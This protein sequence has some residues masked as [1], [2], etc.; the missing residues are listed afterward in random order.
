MTA[1]GGTGM[2]LLLSHDEAHKA[3]LR[4]AIDAGGAV[5]WN[6]FARLTGTSESAVKR[7]WA[8]G[9]LPSVPIDSIPIREGIV[10]LCAIPGALRRGT[11]TPLWLLEFD[12]QARA[13]LGLPARDVAEVYEAR[14]SSSSDPD[15]LDRL[16]MNHLRAQTANAMHAAK[17]K[18]F[19][20][21]V[22]RGEYVK[23]S[24]VELDAAECAT[25]VIGVLQSL[26]A[27]IGAACA[28]QSALEIERRAADEI[29]RAVRY[30]QTA[31]M[32]GDW[33]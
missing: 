3:R 7:A 20:L 32:T 8:D 9:A 1:C 5:R 15:E 12:A 11:T 19:D 22:K 27:R 14:P 18:E 30:I 24:E 28:G 16:R 4:A 10:A 29:A 25:N 26:P 17:A 33:S 2:D 31:A 6:D 23:T 13:L 21:S